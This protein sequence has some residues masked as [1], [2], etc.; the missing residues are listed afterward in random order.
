M[1]QSGGHWH[2]NPQLM[3]QHSIPQGWQGTWPPP[4]GVSLPPNFPGPPPMPP[5]ANT[6]PHWKAGF[7]QYNPAYNM[8]GGH[9]VPWAPGMGWAQN[10]PANFN[11]H[12]R[13]PRPASPSYWQTRLTDNGLG[14]ENM[15]PARSRTRIC[16]QRCTRGYCATN[17]V[18]MES[19]KSVANGWSRPCYPNKGLQQSSELAG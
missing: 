13:V 18:D 11:P 1:A 17:P 10:V 3:Q 19:S 9:G 15:V 16:Y 12:K 4:A 7:W 14:L 2:P 5:G 8:N 6:H